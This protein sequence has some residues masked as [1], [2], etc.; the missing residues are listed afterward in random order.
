[1]FGGVFSTMCL[2]PNSPFFPT[3][4]LNEPKKQADVL[5]LLMLGVDVGF[6]E[7]T[8]KPPEDNF[9]PATPDTP[10]LTVRLGNRLGTLTTP[11]G[12]PGTRMKIICVHAAVAGGFWFCG[13]RWSFLQWFLVTSPYFY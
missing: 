9:A 10:D 2:F 3:Q 13:N 11:E 1:M 6:W 5:E 7:A 12:D 8:M 4:M